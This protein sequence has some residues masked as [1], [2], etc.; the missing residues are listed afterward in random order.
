LAN[1]LPYKNNGAQISGNDNG[2]RTFH[3]RNGVK[4]YGGFS[5]ST[6]ETSLTARDIK[7]NQTIL[8]GIANYHIVVATSGATIDGFTISGGYGD[9]D[10]SNELSSYNLYS[11]GPFINPWAGGAINIYGS[12]T[13][14]NNIFASNRSF[15]GGAIFI[16]YGNL[17]A[18]NNVFQDNKA[19]D[20]SLINAEYSTVALYNNTFVKNYGSRGIWSNG[21]CISRNNLFYGNTYTGTGDIDNYGGSLTMQYCL[22]QAGS[23]YIGGTGNIQGDPL[24]VDAANN[25]FG[26]QSGSPCI[27]AGTPNGAPSTDILG[28][29]R[30]AN[31][32]IGAYEFCVL[33]TDYALT[34]TGSY[35]NGGIAAGLP[36]SE[37]GISY[38]LKNFTTNI[39][40]PIPGT[41]SAISFSPK[42]AAGTYTVVATSAVGCKATMSGKIDIN[43]TV[44]CPSGNTL[45][46]NASVSG[47]TGDGTSWANAYASLGDALKTARFCGQVKTIKVAQGTYKPTRMPFSNGIEIT[48]ADNRSMTFHIPDGVTMEGGY[49]ATTGIRNI[50]N[51]LTIL[52]GDIGTANVTTDNCYHVVASLGGI[53]VTIDGFSITGGNANSNSNIIL[54]GYSFDPSDGSGILV[55][56]GTNTISNN[57]IYNNTAS[58]IGGGILTSGSNNTL[59]NNILYNNTASIQG[60]GIYTS[61]SNNTLSNNILYNNTASS[62]GGGIYTSNSNNTLSNNILYN[63]TASSIGGGIFA[64]EGKH[65][66]SNNTLYNNTASS[67]GGGIYIYTNSPTTLNNN[68]F[69]ANKKGT[70]DNVAGADF[71]SEGNNIFKNNILQ[72]ASSNY[73]STNK[74]VLATTSSGNFFAQNPNFVSTSNLI[75]ADGKHRTADDGLQLLACS[76]AIDGG[77]SSNGTPNNIPTTDILG[78]AIYNGYKDIGAFERNS[79]SNNPTNFMLTGAGNYC[80]PST[81]NILGLSGSEIG[82]TYQLKNSAGTNVGTAIN[83]TGAA[84]TFAG[85]QATGTYTVV[86]TKTAASCSTTMQGNAVVRLIP[87]CCPS[88]NVTTLHVNAA[89]V[90][91]IGDGSTWANAYANLSDALRVAYF[92]PLIKKIKIASGTYKPSRKPFDN[93]AEMTTTDNRDRTFHI[94]DGVTIEGGYNATTGDRLPSFGGAGGGTILS[95][96]IDNNDVIG[97]DGKI[98]SGNANNVYHV[99]LASAASTDG[100][101]VM[102]DGCAITGANANSTSSI[103]VNGNDIYRYYGGGI[104]ANYGTNMLSNN[105]LY[106][107]IAYYGG[108]INTNYGTNTLNNNIIY[109]NSSSS[110]GGGIYAIYGTNT[111]NNNIIYGNSSSFGGGISANYGTNTLN[112]N[113]IYSNSAN[114]LGGGIY[115][116]GSTNTLINN[117]FW[118]NK[119]WTDDAVAYSDYAASQAINIFKNNLMQLGES[120]YYGGGSSSNN[121]LGGESSNNIFPLN[122]G[123]VNVANPAGADGKYGTADDGLQ[124]SGCSPAIDAG[125]LTI[126]T[127]ALDILG[128]PIYNNRKDIGAYELQADKV[129]PVRYVNAAVSGGNSDGTSWANA[130]AS[131][132]D[133]LA[134]ARNTCAYTT[135]KVAVGTYKPTKKAFNYSTEITTT[136]NRDM[137]FHIP[138]GVTIEGGYDASTGTRTLPLSG[139]A[140]G[141]L[142]SILSGD[143]G[144]AN[145]DSDNCYHVVLAVT[146][147]GITIDGFSITGGRSYL[148]SSSYVYSVNRAYIYSNVGAGLHI[149]NG[150]NTISNNS[151]YGNKSYNNS[152]I[153]LNNSTNIKKNANFT[154]TNNKV[155]GNSSENSGGGVSGIN[156]IITMNDNTVYEN[157]AVNYGAGIS[158]ISCTST[159]TN[160]K[161]YGN[162][163]SGSGYIKGSG[164]SVQYGSIVMDKN[165]LYGNT[166]VGS[167]ESLGGGA[168]IESAN[169]EL[170]NNTIYENLALNGKGGGIYIYGQSGSMYNNVLY[171]NV[172]ENGG[173]GIYVS[174][175]SLSMTNNTLYNNEVKS[176][177]SG[178]G[179]YVDQSNCTLENNIF[180]ANK[181]GAYSQVPFA[182]FQPNGTTTAYNNIFQTS[183]NFLG[184]PTGNGNIFNQNPNFVNTTDPAGA[185]GIHGTAD[186]G[187]ALQNGSLAI[188]AGRSGGDA[189]TTDITGATRSG[190]P[191]IGAYENIIPCVPPVAYNVTGGGTFCAGGAGVAIG[192]SNSATDISYQ[193]KNGTSNV[194]SAVS[195]T[196]AALSFGNQLAAGTY[197]VVATKTAGCTLAMTGSATITV[198]SAP[199]ASIAA[200]DNCGN[201]VLNLTI[202]PSGAGAFLWSNAATTEDI[203]VAT[204]GTYTVTF[205]DANGC[206]ATASGTAAPKAVP[207][208]SIAVTNNCGNSLLNLTTSGTD[209]LWST[210]ATTEDLTVAATGTYTVTI[211]DANSC[212]TTTSEVAAPNVLPIAYNVTGGGTICSNDDGGVEIGLF[213]SGIGI[214]YQ[215][216]NGANN[217]GSAINGTGSAISFGNHLEPGTYTVVATKVS[218]GCSLTMTSSAVLTVNSA[219]SANITVT[220]NCG[221][222]VLNLTTSPLGAGGSFLWT[223]TATTED[224]TVSTAGAYSVTVT[225]TE[226]CTAIANGI[227]MPNALPS[228]YNVTGGG[229]L[230]SNDDGGV[231]ISLSNSEIGVSY[232]LKNG[233]NNVGSP[234]NGTGAALSFGNHLDPGS[235]TVVATNASN[236][237]SSTMTNSA[238]ITVHQYPTVVVTVT[239][240]CG[241]SVLNVNGTGI[242]YVWSNGATDATTTV[243]NA[244]VYSVTVTG[245]GG[246]TTVESITA[247]PKTAASVNI[248]V[249]NNCGNAVLS[250]TATSIIGG[251]YLWSNAATTEDITVSTAGAYSVTVTNAEGC[252]ATANGTATPNAVTTASIAVTNNC[253]NSVLNLTTSGTGFLWSNAATTEDITVYTAGVYTVTIT[254]SNGCTATV[255]GT[256]TPN[257]GPTANITVTNNCGNSLLNLT[258]NGT[259]YLWSNAATTEDITVS[260][261]GT[262]TVTITDSNGCTAT[263]SEVTAPNALPIAYNV[264]GGGAYCAGL[265]GVEIGL[266]NSEIGISYQL[267]IGNVNVGTAIAGTGSAISFGNQVAGTYTVVATNPS[268]GCSSTM[269]NSATIT[270]HPFP[271]VV[272]TVINNCGNSVLNVNGTGTSYVWSNGA[273]GQTIIVDNA[274]VYS[275]TATGVG[276]C[277]VVESIV[278]LPK[279][280]A[281][282]N[283]TVANNCGNSVLNLTTSPSGAGDSFLWS[284]A[285]TTEDIT[286]STAGNYSVTVTNAEGCTATANGTATPFSSAI[287]YNITGGGAYCAGLD[288]VEIGLDGSQIGLSYQLQRSNV[289]VGTAITGTGSAISFGKQTEAGIYSVIATSVSAGCTKTMQNTATVTVDATLPAFVSASIPA[290]VTINC[291]ATIPTAATPTVTNSC[292]TVSFV[293]TSTKTTNVNECSYYSFTVTRIWTATDK[294]GNTVTASQIITVQDNVAPTIAPLA[295]ITVTA[296]AIPTT[297]A[298]TDNCMT[299]PTVTF[300]ET[301]VTHTPPPCKNYS[302]TLNRIWSVTDACGN[303]ATKTQTIKAEGIYLTC[304]SDKTIYTNSDGVNNYNCSSL[305]TAAMGVAPTFTDGCDASVLR[306]TITGATTGT[307]N[308]S[309]AGIAFAKGVS[310]ITY[311]LV[312]SVSD[313]CSL[314]LTVLDNEAPKITLTPTVVLDACTVPNPIPNTYNPSVLDN[315]TGTNTFE[316]MS[317]VLADQTGCAT[318]VAAQKYTKL[319][320]RTWKATDENGN[321][322]TAVQKI[323]LRDMAP[324]ITVCK[325]VTVNIGSSNITLPVSS[326]NNGSNDNCTAATALTFVGC[327]NTTTAC[328][329]FGANLTLKASMIPVGQNQATI[330]VRVKARDAC[331]NE[332]ATPV[333]T[334]IT[335]KRIGTMNNTTNGSEHS[336]AIQ[337]TESSIPAE[338]S[339]VPTAQGE[340]K[341]YPTP[342]S[343]DLNIQYNLTENVENVTLKLYDTQ[344][345]LVTKMEQEAQATGFYQVRWNLSDLSAG[346]YHVCLELNGKCTKMER[347][348]MMK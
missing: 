273:N 248:T 235:Y 190:I 43:S 307:G 95:G 157:L 37:T 323:Y 131:L 340:M 319:L 83:G 285:A 108:G 178:A 99:V 305:A 185:D 69:W 82:V 344:G 203:T 260:N 269:T 67:N 133:A 16:Q 341:C 140:G 3:V 241:N 113:T 212:T 214:S 129:N 66:L 267:Q 318:K 50:T 266:D 313:Q 197:T 182:D 166:A 195:G 130:Y 135:I 317:D 167:Y 338:A 251:T 238:T 134:Y 208:A 143:I 5:A 30:V 300:T 293:E 232:Q 96:D 245:T 224:I 233:A 152:G 177:S 240:N 270:V 142:G 184:F 242:S 227:A 56:N 256:A 4:I 257:A 325:N 121:G 86:A 155:Y 311:N 329:N 237:C 254:N 107:N 186:D 191:D 328:T 78:I 123:F 174:S 210:G 21:T 106:N 327:M 28:T 73:T 117:I 343:E 122:P 234:M 196:G 188:N 6:P 148:Y 252:T 93:F 301:K 228:A 20:A 39:D 298:N 150:N 223:N 264:T 321:T 89:V 276:G 103:T 47:G 315:C 19:G 29:P 10:K 81:G 314:N 115:T 201:S 46:V 180:W 312:S 283:I 8:S 168:Y 308:G 48:S 116:G 74:N 271:T 15:Y 290:N 279:T 24:F 100:I 60:G 302:Y 137:T 206:S 36:N 213:N 18:Y 156:S 287:T 336:M 310:T 250:A 147:S 44:C 141:G 171:S 159:L 64:S 326:L 346:M 337:D 132:D 244:G 345:R 275:V 297:I 54:D 199:T 136:D 77:L 258:T 23:S 222:S 109:S 259:S 110:F 221:N 280:V 11:G 80:S 194:G 209:F 88:A 219:P 57:T 101:G 183:N 347:V 41:G 231:E 26:L 49:N 53:G 22:L 291:N 75:G 332:T 299:S 71:Y 292:S 253:G 288:G 59:S 217:I 324:P 138:D 169:Y 144:V 9:L 42:T 84:I 125:T 247:S 198:N 40:A 330:T 296:G 118:A 268:N 192:L 322:S 68:I 239:N 62:I 333:S 218:N 225:N 7:A 61:N 309:V 52:S 320:T 179:I 65:K 246:C 94:P 274:G 303:S 272:V 306:Y 98:S 162:Y 51:N 160:N 261:A 128:N 202:S 230:C 120:S 92:C 45:Y 335:L 176:S 55:I 34:S 334:I 173:G 294:L 211:T 193:L 339:T 146:S 342:F 282:V 164:L 158:L 281:T 72:L 236:G 278:A 85:N 27:N 124:L 262:Y 87:V 207:T 91:G 200:T 165:R 226:G 105:A 97:T 76:P 63:N 163:L 277:G 149:T 304:P 154:L 31:P 175:S 1:S 289:N 204:A 126:G 112:N 181:R 70:A 32:D 243:D 13:L 205:T 286:V 79:S 284:N 104:S 215:L 145:D 139:G 25:N 170:S 229:D 14:A 35:C 111:L 255:S 38:Q 127:P 263:T 348:I 265:D 331:G 216:K 102:I 12:C 151:V 189:P 58:G 114:D 2:N 153:F 187:L 249:V 161:I 295:N 33:P 316:V 90:G 172:G 119:K 17:T 220:N